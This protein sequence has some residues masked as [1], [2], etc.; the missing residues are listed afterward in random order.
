MNCISHIESTI[1]PCINE[2]IYHSWEKKTSQTNH[3]QMRCRKNKQNL[4]LL[5]SVA[6]MFWNRTE[7]SWGLVLLLPL[8]PFINY[9]CFC[10]GYSF[11]IMQR[12]TAECSCSHIFPPSDFAWDWK[13][14]KCHWAEHRK[15]ISKRS[16]KKMFHYF[17]QGDDKL[18]GN[19]KCGHSSA[20]SLSGGCWAIWVYSDAHLN[21]IKYAHTVST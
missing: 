9:E 16:R 6:P 21:C 1:S 2:V 15:S 20:S 18:P 3:K 10:L 8:L 13:D 4:V 5:N 14:V 7:K 12:L 11:P 17:E 19:L